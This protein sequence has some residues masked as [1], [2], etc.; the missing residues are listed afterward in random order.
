[1][2]T[3]ND[4]LQHVLATDVKSAALLVLD[5]EFIRERTY[6]PQLAL[7]QIGGLR[8]DGY[9]FY[10]LLDPVALN[11]D[12]LRNFFMEWNRLSIP[13]VIH[14]AQADQECLWYAL[15]LTIQ[16]VFDTAVAAGLLGIGDSVSLVRLAREF[17]GVELQKGYTRA[18]WMMRPLDENLLNYA[19]DDVRYLPTIYKNM[20]RSLQ[21]FGR[22][23][24]VFT[25]SGE[26]SKPEVLEISPEVLAKRILKNNVVDSDVYR[27]LLGLCKLREARA[28]KE[29]LPRKRIATDELLYDLAKARPANIDQLKMFRALS[30][31]EI[32]YAADD[33]LK[34]LSDPEFADREYHV[35]EVF[36]L[37]DDDK[38]RVDFLELM[39][40]VL[41]RQRRIIP[42]Y[43]A[44][45]SQ[46]TKLVYLLNEKS[47]QQALIES[48]S[49][50]Q[51]LLLGDDLTKI[52][53][54]RL[55]LAFRKI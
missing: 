42:K 23:E 10:H 15:D 35:Q 11:K 30:S 25:L 47:L 32:K 5:T 20:Y 54:G 7:I 52:I 37:S 21:G 41:A 34:A 46:M 9:E 18:N 40:K 28:Q 44:S 6:Y 16:N 39:M 24:W 29:D 19:L 27:A 4:G 45:K 22:H 1:M 26:Y 33:W 51:L 13:T 50:S 36:D 38:I 55:A 8:A 17:A 2:I 48:F 14:A 12:E 3:S 49:E 31:S 43:L 53:D